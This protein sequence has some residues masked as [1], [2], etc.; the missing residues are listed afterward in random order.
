[1]KFGKHFQFKFKKYEDSEIATVST[2]NAS[3]RM[4]AYDQS[5]NELIEDKNI[6]I[7][8]F[9]RDWKVISETCNLAVTGFPDMTNNM[10]INKI[11]DIDGVTNVKRIR[12][13]DFQKYIIE[14]NY[15][16]DHD[17]VVDKITNKFCDDDC[18][19]RD[20]MFIINPDY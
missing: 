8:N 10:I 20:I 18:T 7:R 5:R 13:T 15:L 6:D 12:D 9:E 14:T 2:F 1:M 3:D 11:T 17:Y 19:V 4:E 16:I